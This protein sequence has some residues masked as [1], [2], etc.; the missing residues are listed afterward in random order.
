MIKWNCCTCNVD[1]LKKCVHVQ[2]ICVYCVA[3]NIFADCVIKIGFIK[4]FKYINYVTEVVYNLVKDV[5]SA[6]VLHTQTTTHSSNGC[7]QIIIIK[8]SSIY[9][10]FLNHLNMKLLAINSWFLPSALNDVQ[11]EYKLL[12]EYRCMHDI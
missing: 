5:R 10:Q 9:Q 6:H 11:Y 4:L 12:C 8:I 2:D 1:F 7:I 3:F